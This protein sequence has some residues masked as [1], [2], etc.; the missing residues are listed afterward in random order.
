VI[1]HQ[2]AAERST[3]SRSGVLDVAAFTYGMP[4]IEKHL[5]RY[6]K[7]VP[8]TLD[9]QRR[10]R[11]RWESHREA[12]HRRITWPPELIEEWQLERLAAI[13]DHAYNT[14]PFYRDLY[15]RHGYRTGDIVTFDDFNS[16]PIIRKA[17]LI[18]GFPDSIV[19]SGI[20][21]ECCYGARTS[22]STGVPV[23]LIQDDLSA[24]RWMVNRM[25]QFELMAGERIGPMDWVYN[26]YLST[27][28]FTSFAGSYPIF[29]ISEDC[30]PDAIYRH[31]HK[32]RPKVLSVF[33]SFLSRLAEHGDDLFGAGVR[34]ICTNSESSSPEERRTYQEHFGVPVL[35]E[36]ASEELSIIATECRFGRY[37]VV[38]DRIRVDVT[39]VGPD[40]MGDILGTDL[41]NIYLPL[42]RYAQGDLIRWTGEFRSCECGNNFRSFDR[43]LG[44]A[45][46]TLRSPAIGRVPSDRVMNLCDRTLVSYES[47]VAQFRLVQH[48]LDAV[49]VFLVLRTPGRQASA[50][51]LEE[52]C[53]GL[54]N[55]FQTDLD[56]RFSYVTALPALSS[57]K[58]RMILSEVG[59]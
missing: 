57:H 42:I 14:I 23:S 21:P 28:S 34:C 20:D 40:G 25:R 33:P 55:L 11:R 27:W 2:A 52:F 3:Q 6:H 13:V 26:V 37:H 56:V 44:R 8:E 7:R 59:T 58:R 43:F 51:I 10:L 53:T 50:S 49:E 17:D 31:I 54:R 5:H 35:D 4:E 38:E 19:L 18:E 41:S 9:R 48:S 45:D 24:D 16:L 47:G 36:Y 32:L 30:P 15:G 39:N 46:Q 22:G 12:L 1:Q 29:S